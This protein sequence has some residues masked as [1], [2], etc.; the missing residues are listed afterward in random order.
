MIAAYV[1]K[2]RVSLDTK[3]RV[4]E[5]AHRQ[6]LSESQWLRR[7]VAAALS[8]PRLPSHDLNRQPTIG[9]S[10]RPL[11]HGQGLEPADRGRTR[12]YIR[13]RHDDRTI[14]RE[15]AEARG[16]PTSTYVAALLRAHL[17]NLAPLPQEEL[18]VLKRLI[19]ELGAIGRNLNQMARVAHQ[20]GRMVTP[21]RDDVQSML[22]ICEAMRENIKTLVRSNTASWECGYVEAAD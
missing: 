18:A 15:R 10:G 2:T 13:L 6:L 4:D 12:V 17:R 8:R 11:R 19:A 1:I 5:E 16:M 20:N 7:V 9:S 14:L 22:R 3:V 21:G